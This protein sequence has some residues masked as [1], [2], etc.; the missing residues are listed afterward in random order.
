MPDS[1]LTVEVVLLTHSMNEVKTTDNGLSLR[2]MVLVIFVILVTK[3]NKL[4]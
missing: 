1:S 4:Q 3:L 2:S